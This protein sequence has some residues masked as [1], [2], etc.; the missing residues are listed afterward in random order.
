[1]NTIISV[2]TE[3][4]FSRAFLMSCFGSRFRISV[5]LDR[6]SRSEK[7]VCGWEKSYV[8][9]RGR[10]SWDSEEMWLS[11]SREV[12]D[13]L[14][15]GLPLFFEGRDGFLMVPGAYFKNGIPFLSVY[16][17]YVYRVQGNF[18]SPFR[19]DI[20]NASPWTLL[21]MDIR[22]CEALPSNF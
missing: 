13:L 21:G 12:W 17:W 22:N 20:H 7:L 11:L 16:F 4:S 5:I 10:A 14:I 3:I 18:C 6:H 1:M 8:S 15:E 9:E 19:R 2:T